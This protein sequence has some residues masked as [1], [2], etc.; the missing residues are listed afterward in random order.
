MTVVY[1]AVV[2]AALVLSVALI[3]LV[4]AAVRVLRLSA[5]ERQLR[6]EWLRLRNDGVVGDSDG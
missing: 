4:F 2:L 3:V 1:A 5:Q 6:I